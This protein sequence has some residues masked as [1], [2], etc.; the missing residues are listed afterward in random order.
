[1][2]CICRAIIVTLLITLFAVANCVD[3]E[4]AA[5]VIAIRTSLVAVV[6]VSCCHTSLRG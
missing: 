6:F 5:A 1:M 2:L 3:V 4:I